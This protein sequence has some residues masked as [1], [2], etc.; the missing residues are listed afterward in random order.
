MLKYFNYT[1][2]AEDADFNNVVDC[3]LEL[4]RATYENT[5]G[6]DYADK[7][8]EVLTS[9]AKKSVEGTKY[10][11][12][13]EANGLAIFKKPMVTRSYAVRENFNAI[14]AQ[15][16]TAIVPEVTNDVFSRYIAEVHQV[17][18][19]ET[20][21]FIIESNDLF[22]VNDKAEG[23]LKGVDQP[24]FD[25]E[26]TVNAHPVTIDAAI[27]WYPF[28][29]GIFD[30]GNFALKIG[31]SFMSYIFVK[32]VKGMTQASTAYGAAYSINGV[33]MNDFCT[34]RDRVKAANGGM[35]VIAIGTAAA[36][37]NL[38]LGGNFQ[39]QIGEEMNKV[40][41]LDQY[42]Q[43]PLL[44]LDNVLVPGTTNSTAILALPNNRIYLV[45]AAGQRPVK[46]LFEGEEVAVSFDA[47]RTSDKRYGISVEM[48]IGVE[49]VLGPKYGTIIL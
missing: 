39:V 47:D 31:K 17:G 7:N 29:A 27:D 1:V 23:I 9:I 36:L 6:A 25:D 45:P 22:V 10:E 33:S 37:G 44:A 16:C 2:N 15:I 13:F 30:M 19:G 42:L 14:I 46:I 41:Y 49:V 18:Y 26:I 40:G 11:A 38:T 5:K 4:A 3:A 12:D 20:A 32:V 24:M 21:R 8:K 35:P 34:L 28:A 43:T 48:R